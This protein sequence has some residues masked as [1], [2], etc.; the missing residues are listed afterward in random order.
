MPLPVSL[1][2]HSYLLLPVI[3]IVVGIVASLSGLRKA[4]SVDPALAF[5]GP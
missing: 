5:G 3:A 4:V 2:L 1:T